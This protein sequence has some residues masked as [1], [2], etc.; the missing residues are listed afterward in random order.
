MN[1]SISETMDIPKYA[2]D[3]F[4]I[5]KCEPDF[6]DQPPNS[7]INS[8]FPILPVGVIGI[9]GMMITSVIVHSS[10]KDRLAMGH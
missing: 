9:L 7:L 8:C 10:S 5:T 1:T 3:E 4:M 2:S 6:G